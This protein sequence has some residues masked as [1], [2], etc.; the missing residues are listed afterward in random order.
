M[1]PVVTSNGQKFEPGDIGVVRTGTLFGLLIRLATRSEYN[2]AFVVIDKGLITEAAMH[3][4]TVTPLSKYTHSDVMS[5]NG[6]FKIS[7]PERQIIVTKALSL[8]G[9]GYNFL[10]IL[11]IAILQIGWVERRVR[12]HEEGFLLRWVRHR[13][14]SSR[15]LI[16]SQ[17]ADETY[18]LAGLHI[19][20]D[21]RIPM[22]VTPGDLAFR[23][24]ELLR[25]LM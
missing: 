11:S 12:L 2:H 23:F 6:C 9:R 16:C 19:F 7:G 17:D 24:R 4:V 13:V 14:E 20:D 5:S 18:R 21:G 15:R 3:G 22:D 25:S 1:A 10:D 8:V